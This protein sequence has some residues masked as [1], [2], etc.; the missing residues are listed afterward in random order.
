MAQNEGKICL[1][2]SISHEEAKVHDF[3]Y[4]LVIWLWFLVHKCKMM[5]SRP[6]AFF[7]FSKFWFS[8]LLGGKRGGVQKL[9]THSVST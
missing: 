9:G 1:S 4:F 3:W 5:A 8:G 6:D 7:I 2:I